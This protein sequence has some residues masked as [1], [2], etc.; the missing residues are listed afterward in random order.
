ML[1]SGLRVKITLWTHYAP[2]ST[3]EK[4]VI[5]YCCLYHFIAPKNGHKEE[6]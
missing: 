1:G 3:T 5:Q 4:S 6:Q 2:L